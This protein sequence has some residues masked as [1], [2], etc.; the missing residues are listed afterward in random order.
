MIPRIIHYIWFGDP[1]K[2]PINRIESWKRAL[3]GWE[4]REWTERE[5]ADKTI[6]GYD[7]VK[8]AYAL[9]LYALCTDPLRFLI[10]QEFG[11]IWFDTDVVVHR[12]LT[13]LLDC[14]L[15]L[16]RHPTEGINVGVIGIQAGHPLCQAVLDHYEREWSCF[17]EMPK[18]KFVA[19]Y[20]TIY[21]PEKIL[22]QELKQ[23][24]GLLLPTDSEDFPTQEDGVFRFRDAFDLSIVGKS[25][26]ELNYT[27]HLRERSWW[28]P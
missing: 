3:A 18:G 11:G 24:Y 6:F 7:F 12:D 23:R 1:A 9:K 10:L 20:G 27:E 25:H 22:M 2:K 26:P 5:L 13:P 17:P 16:G 15:L 28:R 8:R 21:P 4:I 14:S 19:Q